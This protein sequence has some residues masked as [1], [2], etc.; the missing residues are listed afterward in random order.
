[1]ALFFVDTSYNGI[2]LQNCLEFH[3]EIDSV[4]STDTKD[5]ISARIPPKTAFG[6]DLVSYQLKADTASTRPS[7]WITDVQVCGKV[8]PVFCGLVQLQL[9]RQAYEIEK[10]VCNQ[11]PHSFWDCTPADWPQQIE[12]A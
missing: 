11:H 12:T 7:R 9:S 5:H 6:F 4:L 10:A 3:R 2:R 8:S 1:M